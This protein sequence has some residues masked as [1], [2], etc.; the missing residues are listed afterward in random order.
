MCIAYAMETVRLCPHVTLPVAADHPPRGQLTCS[1]VIPL[2]K[3]KYCLACI[4][5]F[6][7]LTAPYPC[8]GLANGLPSAPAGMLLLQLS[9]IAPLATAPLDEPIL[10]SQQ[11]T[12]AA[13]DAGVG[14]GHG[15]KITLC[16][17]HSLSRNKPV[18]LLIVLLSA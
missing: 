9:L 4:R 16:T 2:S 12:E 11:R 5:C 8:L 7:S 1:L 18:S 10:I 13:R 15:D 14:A 17:H 3:Y 6:P